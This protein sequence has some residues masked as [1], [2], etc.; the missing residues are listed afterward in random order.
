MHRVG[1]LGTAGRDTEVLRDSKMQDVTSPGLK[2]RGEGTVSA[3]RGQ[4]CMQWGPLGA[5]AGP[6]ERS[7][8]SGTQGDGY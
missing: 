7:S 1:R 5:G 4:S 8:I 3:E 6:V 2:G